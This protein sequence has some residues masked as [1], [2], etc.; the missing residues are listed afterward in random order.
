MT[1]SSTQDWPERNWA[2]AILG[3]LVGLAIQQLADG[4]MDDVMRPGQAEAV[5][6]TK[7]CEGCGVEVYRF[8]QTANGA[9]SRANDNA[10][11]TVNWAAI[12]KAESGAIKAGKV[13]IREV[14]RRQVYVDGKPAGL[15]FE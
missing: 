2:I 6:I 12:K 11:P 4:K 5:A 1:E 9:W 3:A 7:P 10:P 14:R 13:E 15:P 8:T